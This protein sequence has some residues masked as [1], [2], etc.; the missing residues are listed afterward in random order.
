MLRN[1][2]KIA[3]RNLV[4]HKVFSSINLAGLAIGMAGC[5]LILL[6]VGSELSYDRFNVNADRIW[7]LTREWFNDNGATN[8]HLG[9]VAPIIAPLFHNDFP[10]ILEILRINSPGSILV[11]RGERHFLEER[12]LFAD[13]NIF[14]VFT[15]PL[16]KG[17]PVAALKEPN[18]VVVTE[19]TARKY[20]GAEDPIGKTLKVDGRLDCT[21][22][23]VV[24]EAPVNAHFHFDFIGSLATLLEL[25]GRDEFESWGSNN[26][27]T[28][29]LLPP[30]YPV[31]SLRD[32]LPAFLDRHLNPQ[33]HRQNA[34]HLQRL[35]DIHL[36]SNLDSEIEANSDIAYVYIMTAIGVFILLIA[37]FNFMNLTTARA[38]IRAKEVGLRKVVGA[39]RR[40]LFR[41][42]MSES[43]LLALV[44]M[45]IAVGL[46]MLARPALAAFLSRDLNAGTA[47]GPFLWAAVLA[48]AILVGVLAGSYP[49][50]VLS[51]MRPV[52]VLKGSRGSR[53]HG[54]SFRTVLVVLQFA[55]SISLIICVGIV[56]KQLRYTRDKRLGFD[57]ERIAVLGLD[58]TMRQRY[59][60]IREQL[61]AFPGIEEAAGSR[62][63]PS[64]R[65]LDSS[66]AAIVSGS[67]NRPVNF[68]IALDCVDYAFIDTYKMEM[69]AGRNFSRDFPT[70]AQSA[71]ILNEA[72][73]R[74]LGW[75]AERAVGRPFTYGDDRKGLIVGVVKDFHF[76]SLHQEIAPLVFYINPQRYR[77]ISVRI[78]PGRIPETLDF[79]RKKWA[80]WRP[81]Y[82]FEYFFVDERFSTLYESERKLGQI[83]RGF[84]F[85]AVF[86]A[87]LG[88]YGL[89][90]FSAE[91]RTREIGIR[92]VL[93]ASV[94]G[95]ALRMSQDFTKWVLAANVLA[96]PLSY[97]VMRH[98]L[99][100]FAYRVSP[101][102][103][104]FL[105]A[106]LIAFLIALATVS[107]LAVKAA[108]RSP[109]EALRVE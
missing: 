35:T 1:Y 50:F 75:T 23:G 77:L 93:G 89:A 51:A 52:S 95:L 76:E 109:A 97:Y 12:F 86:V 101:G 79:L 54:A 65:L 14:K 40:Q 107:F 67:E 59:D 106:G 21:V 80:E 83:F 105:L 25:Y 36:R 49:A 100:G 41:Q 55:I 74:K 103:G 92:K 43:I 17:D 96:W 9:H 102:L 60:A 11:S 64:G 37:C 33:A 30:R 78:R 26:Y 81:N 84:S 18:T 66:G 57:K 90:S 24:T 72:A 70:D 2:L 10:E 32:R 5:I 3:M 69:A 87:C 15:F 88:L 56:G 62:R 82:P 39:D 4:K 20:F 104:P 46:A 16:R 44:A 108:I 34:L 45:G 71:F 73:V 68:R 94:P 58:D 27:A 19:H 13:E 85:L 98:W 99:Q 8:L 42:F 61:R 48:I 91:K 22:T 6:F 63:V 29:L 31:E 53:S 7:R 28:Y 47:G 38:S